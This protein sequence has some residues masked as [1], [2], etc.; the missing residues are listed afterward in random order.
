MVE[1]TGKCWCGCGDDCER[2]FFVPGHDQRA[3][4][5]ALDRLGYG[6]HGAIAR[7]LEAH[8]FQP[9][10][11]RSAELREAVAKKYESANGPSGLE[12]EQMATPFQAG[13]RVRSVQHTERIGT[14]V[15]WG[16]QAQATMGRPLKDLPVTP[17]TY[18]VQWDGDAEP[19]RDIPE[20]WLEL[21]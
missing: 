18:V 4:Y 20:E 9:S 8:D 12:A 19:E 13:D 3:L 6:E 10:G 16:L 7:F 15:D 2:A 17:I 11:A 1:P 21:A 5:A 14:V